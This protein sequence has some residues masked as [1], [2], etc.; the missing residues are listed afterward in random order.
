MNIGRS[1]LNLNFAILASIVQFPIVTKQLKVEGFIVH[2]WVARWT[3]GITQMK[4][5]IT[6]D[7]VKYRET[8]TEGFENMVPAFVDMLKGKNFGKAVV[9]V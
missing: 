2:R 7:K 4:K 8:V 9:K 6:E 3:E 1:S 5:W